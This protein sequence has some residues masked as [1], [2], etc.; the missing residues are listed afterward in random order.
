MPFQML[1]I[2]LETH[3]GKWDAA[4]ARVAGIEADARRKEI[5]IDR[6]GNIL[7]AAGRKEEARREYQRAL[8][9]I[10]S[11]PPKSRSVRA[12]AGLAGSLRRKLAAQ[13]AA[14]SSQAAAAK[15]ARATEAS[16]SAPARENNR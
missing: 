11:L 9:Y 13:D 16:S 4:L 15:P 6:R 5:W 8:A 1:A 14:V 10:A 7:A 3:A 12:T 2:E